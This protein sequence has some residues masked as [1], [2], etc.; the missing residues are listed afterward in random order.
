[1]TSVIGTA[2]V[3]GAAGQDG[4]HLS[5]HLV[6]NGWLVHAAVR[7]EEQA[8]RVRCYEP[9]ARVVE[10]DVRDPAAVERVVAETAPTAVFNLAAISSVARSWREPELVRATNAD[11]VDSL[12]AAITRA[13][14]AH[15]SPVRF[16]QASSAEVDRGSPSPYAEAKAAAEHA[17]RRRREAGLHASIAVL[18]A[19]ES[20]LRP[21]TFVSRK[22]TRAAAE[23]A[24]GRRETLE[25]GNL[26][27][28]RDWGAARDHVVALELMAL[29]DEPGDFEIG[30]G[31]TR[32]LEELVTIAFAAAGVDDPWQH[33]VQD[34]ALLRPQ[35]AS[36]IVAD[37][38]ETARDLG[39]R[40]T[41]PFEEVVAAMVAADLDR[42][43][44]GV[45][46]DPDYLRRRF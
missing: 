19:H 18:H 8:A 31:T 3:T 13:E 15:G 29:R 9:D 25:L 41:T 30:T 24:T 33:V 2:L 39:W 37:V 34:P 46:D 23:I 28:H 43:R 11:A 12:L 42:L 44:T 21:L 36:R 26:D 4:I 40:A 38:T 22:I 10:L 14:S 27:V 1:M 32:S 5:R 45:E 7:T 16:V 20:A 17:V 6:G 35:D